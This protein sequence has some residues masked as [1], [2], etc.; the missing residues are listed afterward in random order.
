MKQTV[1]KPSTSLTI[2]IKITILQKVGEDKLSDR[3][4]VNVDDTTL[5]YLI[6]MVGINLQNLMNEIRKLIEYAG[7]GNTITKDA[8]NELAIKQIESVIFDLT[9][10]LGKKNIENSLIVLKNLL[11]AKEPIQKIFVT[12]YNHFKK[13]YITKI[14]LREKLNVAESLNLKPNQTFLTTKYKQQAKYFEEIE[15]NKILKELSN[16]D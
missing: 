4:K 1:L 14:A 3:Y 5:N 10:S 8:V 13:I 6:E 12:L 7:E 2:S 9:D 15:L 11:Y 16:L